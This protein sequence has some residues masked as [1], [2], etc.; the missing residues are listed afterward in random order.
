MVPYEK[1]HAV[2]HCPRKGLVK[3]E[4]VPAITR[5]G[6]FICRRLWPLLVLG[7]LRLRRRPQ[8]LPILTHRSPLIVEE[9]TKERM[10]KTIGAGLPGIEFERE[11]A[12]CVHTE[13]G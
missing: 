2:G 1:S 10:K 13:I 7:W 8:D 11:N 12:C 5:R 3:R 6:S 4:N 9:G